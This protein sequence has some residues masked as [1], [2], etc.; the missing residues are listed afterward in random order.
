MTP[1]R[2]AHPAR[3]R[4]S[5]SLSAADHLHASLE[6]AP[7]RGIARTRRPGRRGPDRTPG[8]PR[9]RQRR[10]GRGASPGATGPPVRSPRCASAAASVALASFRSASPRPCA[11]LHPLPSGDRPGP[12][13]PARRNTSISEV[14]DDHLARPEVFLVEHEAAR[15]GSSLNGAVRVALRVAV[16]QRGRGTAARTARPMAVPVVRRR[17]RRLPERDAHSV[18]STTPTKSS[19]A[20]QRCQKQ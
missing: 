1:V 9:R 5:L 2:E 4:C 18:R 12:S 16:G 10:P 11:A 17:S 3:L 19:R 6:R 14:A 8:V 20:W 15:T 13:R 7:R